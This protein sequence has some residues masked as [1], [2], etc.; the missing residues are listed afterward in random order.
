MYFLISRN[1]HGRLSWHIERE[2]YAKQHVRC[3]RT[4]LNTKCASASERASEPE[5]YEMKKRKLF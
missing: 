5:Q 1:S 2:P 3:V 4:L